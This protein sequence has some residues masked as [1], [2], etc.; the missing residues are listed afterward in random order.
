LLRLTTALVVAALAAWVVQAHRA[1]RADMPAGARALQRDARGQLA[2]LA[3]RRGLTLGDVVVSLR[4]ISWTVAAASALAL[5]A[6]GLAPYLIAG[7]PISGALLVL[8]VTIA[9][10]FAVSVTLATLLWAE[11]HVPESADWRSVFA[12]R[13]LVGGHQP[14]DASASFAKLCFWL[15]LLLAPV[16]V[17]SILLS[18][19]PAFG[20]QS[21]R[22]LLTLH[23]LSAVAFLVIGTLHAHLLSRPDPA[24]TADTQRIEPSQQEEALS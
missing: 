21:Q 9:P 14:G 20:T 8:H 2:R 22:T 19:L 15:L 10:L 24:M 1:G 6:T 11:H 3:N 5:A 7:S 16:I 13:P 12:T 17:G 18:M 4:V 23:N